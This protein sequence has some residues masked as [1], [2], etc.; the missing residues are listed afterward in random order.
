MEPSIDVKP[1]PYKTRQRTFGLLILIFCVSLPFLYLYATGYRFDLEKPTSLVSTGGIYLA[2]DIL[3]AEIYI[4]D[5][6]V[7][8][9]RTFRK[10]F[11]AQSLDVGTHRV[12]VQKEGYHTWVKELPVSK[13][14]V[15]EAEAFNL[16]L[17]PQVRVISE[18]Q[19]ATGS[20][21]ISK[22]LLY[23]SSTNTVLATTTRATSTLT[24]NQEFSILFPRFA[25]S[26]VQEAAQESTRLERVQETLRGTTTQ[27][28]EGVSI[29]ATSTIVS[30]GVRLS[31]SGDDVFATWVGPFQQMPY[32]YCAPDF[33][34]YTGERN[35]KDVLSKDDERFEEA[36][37]I[38]VGDEGLVMHPVQTLSE[39]IVCEP[40]IRIDR[41][42]Q[43][44]RD[45]DFLP[46]ST[47]FVI[48]ILE[49]GA[50][51]VE[52]DDRAWQNMQPLFL[53]EDLR[54]YIENRNMYLYDGTL[55]YQ[56]IRVIE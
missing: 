12:Y 2:V 26:T 35:S 31:L 4:D 28:I 11:Y 17:V 21:I 23:A 1:L 24:R 47:D 46:G 34:A 51:V 49:D 20:M 8:E 27:G 45:F 50:Y 3:G 33:P 13:R 52:I 30:G 43:M 53:G 10:A 6:L 7:R 16:P 39:D 48:M 44:V 54:L 32:Y 29:Q 25:S 42:N 18:W 36:T 19:S 15:T 38:I 41:K 37:A 55:I 9:T 14:L 56:I 5:E 40:S 22:P